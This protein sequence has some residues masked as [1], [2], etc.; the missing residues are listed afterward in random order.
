MATKKPQAKLIT[1]KSNIR[2]LTNFT[3]SSGFV[4][5]TK[6][7]TYLFT[8][9]RYTESAKSIVKKGIKI[10]E[11]KKDWQEVLK[12]HK[13][14]TL[15]IE[16]DHTT[17]TQLKRY[18]KIFK[19]TTFVNISGKLEEIREVKTKSEIKL[20]KK[21]QEINEKVFKLIK[22][23]VQEYQKSRNPFKKSPTE[24][25]L[26]WKIKQLGHKFGAEDVSFDPII[27]FGKHSALPHH[28]PGKTKLKRNDLVLIDMGMK[29]QGYCSDMTRT[30]LPPKPTEEQKK[31]YN[32]VLKA[33]KNAIKH[34]KEGMTGAKADALSRETIAKA[35]YGEQYSHS[36]GHGVGLDIHETPALSY[37]FKKKLK[38]NSIITVEP[39]IYLNGKFGVRIEDMI[40]VTK[41]G[42]KNLTKIRK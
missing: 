23:I 19:K 42:N 28:H 37:R 39:G 30:L 27:A 34:I 3:G 41:R 5:I 2:Y 24:A 14:T 29:Y 4:I 10:V 15:G 7:Q 18:K 40:L 20:I 21:S 32:L 31:I 36:G 9:S 17:I 25:E 35:G 8:D 11:L 33:Q 38:A 13:I 22:K 1:D 6:T 12:K 26:A 16:E